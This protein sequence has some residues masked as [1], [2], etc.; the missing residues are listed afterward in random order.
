MMQ[1]AGFFAYYAYY[2]CKWAI[3]ILKTSV[4]S[5]WLAGNK[6]LLLLRI[7]GASAG[8]SGLRP[9][10]PFIKVA[11]SGIISISIRKPIFFFSTLKPTLGIKNLISGLVNI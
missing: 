4:A 10:E 9:C 2:A 7:T 5:T 8:L 11:S 3:I 6:F 1:V